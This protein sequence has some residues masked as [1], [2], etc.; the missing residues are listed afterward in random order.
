MKQI[1]KNFATKKIQRLGDWTIVKHNIK[2]FTLGERERH[3]VVVGGRKNQ[4]INTALK[5]SEDGCKLLPSR[6]AWE[7]HSHFPQKINF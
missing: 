5:N 6:S 7:V 1:F 3:D 2:N 4:S